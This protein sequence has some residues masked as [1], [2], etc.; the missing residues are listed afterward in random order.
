VPPP[1]HLKTGETLAEKIKREGK[2]IG[3]LSVGIVDP[4]ALHERQPDL[5]RWLAS[6]FAGDLHYMRNF[7]ERQ[8]RLLDQF[9]DL[10]SILVVTAPYANTPRPPLL[11][12]FG[13]IARYAWGRN[14]HRAIEKRLKRL[15]AFIRTQIP[16]TVRISRCVDT[17]AIQERVLAEMAGLGFIG[18][19]TCL[20][21]PKGGSFVFLAALLTNLELP[22]DKPL[23]WDCGSCTL[24]LEAC[25]TQALAVERPYALDAD[26]C[27]SYLTIEN[28]GAIHPSLRSLVQNWLFGCDICQEVCPYNRKAQQSEWPEFEATAGVGTQLPLKE[29]LEIRT[30]ETFLQRFA[31]TP[32]MRAKRAG[33]V[34]NAAVAAGNAADPGLIPVLTETLQ[35]D[36]SSLVREHAAWALKQLEK[37]STPSNH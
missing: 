36:P 19:N 25:P 18:K 21:L 10:K 4:T 26:R 28:K 31:G 37:S 24:C 32:L 33:L 3:F 1:A 29:I 6:G 2:R 11:H 27:I 23:A 17:S 12:S 22:P 16:E 7:F 34:R 14:Y 35:Q 9:Q 5:T 20:I 15:E 13:Q 30:E 8:R